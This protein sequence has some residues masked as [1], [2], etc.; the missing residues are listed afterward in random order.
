MATPSKQQL[1]RLYGSFYLPVVSFAVV[2]AFTASIGLP[3]ALRLLIPAMESAFF[4]SLP[5]L[6]NVFLSWV[7][8]PCLFVL[9][10]GII[11]V[12]TATSG[13]FTSSGSGGSDFYANLLAKMENVQKQSAALMVEASPARQD[14]VSGCGNSRV[15]DWE[16]SSETH[17]WE[18]SRVSSW[19]DSRVSAA[20]GDDEEES[21][22]SEED[23]EPFRKTT[24]ISR[25]EIACLESTYGQT[26]GGSE[27]SSPLFATPLKNSIRRSLSIDSASLKEGEASESDEAFRKRIEDFILKV[28]A[29]LRSETN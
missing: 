3:A 29:Q 6:W 26:K 4:V 1:L 10:N 22:I 13:I 16:T 9:L 28:N 21:P 17:K 12:L 18:D 27:P 8:P 2:T 25:L 20:E 11:M 15:S 19:G 14:T 5:H 23:E 7:T 24:K